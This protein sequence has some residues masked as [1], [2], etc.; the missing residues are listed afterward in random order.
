V[1]DAVSVE[2]C[3]SAVEPYCKFIESCAVVGINRF[4]R[5]LLSLTSPA[6][7]LTKMPVFWA[8]HRRNNG[9]L[10]VDLGTRSARLHY[11]GFPFFDDRNYRVMV[12]GILCKTLE[13]T[14][15]ERPDVTVRDYTRDSLVVDM[16]FRNVR[17]RD[18][19]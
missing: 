12:R 14:S 4:L 6:Y 5:V 1:L 10:N 13:I 18:G 19:A 9:T 2:A 3:G 16:F 15:G 7:V 8:R 17:L 11:A